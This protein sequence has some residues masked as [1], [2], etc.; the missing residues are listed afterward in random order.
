M[1]K[2]ILICDDEVDTHLLV[3]AALNKHDVE[4]ISVEDGDKAVEAVK[5]NQPDLVIMDYMLP[6]MDGLMT[7]K[8]IK[9]LVADMPVIFM[10]GINI[11]PGEKQDIDELVDT[12]LVKPFDYRELVSTVEKLLNI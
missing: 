2:K 6:S 7:V 11:D 10:T 5:N 8:D 1:G 9:K 4:F 12:Y 3:K